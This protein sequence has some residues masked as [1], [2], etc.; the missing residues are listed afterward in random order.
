MRLRDN[1]VL[2]RMLVQPTPDLRDAKSDLLER[3]ALLLPDDRR[4]VEL[5]I[6]NH[7]TQ[8]QLAELFNIPAGTV[9]RRVR[10]VINRLCDPLVIALLASRG[11][12]AP[13]P[14]EHRQLALEHWL[15]GQ[16]RTELAQTHQISLTEVHR[17]LEFVRGWHRATI[18]R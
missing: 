8:R 16:T 10:K 6:K 3:A 4:L 11:P 2:D 1:T 13:L 17:M 9:C 14:H 5:V 12:R 7:L 15:Q 18:M